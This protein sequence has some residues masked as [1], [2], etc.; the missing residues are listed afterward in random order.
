[1]NMHNNP[2]LR[3]VIALRTLQETF[4]LVANSERNRI[5]AQIRQVLLNVYDH[6]CQ[7]CKCEEATAIDHIIPINPREEDLER[8]ATIIPSISW[9]TLDCI[10]NYMA[11]CQPCNSKKNNKLLSDD[12]LSFFLAKAKE[13]KDEIRFLLAVENEDEEAKIYGKDIQPTTEYIKFLSAAIYGD[14]S[15]VENFIQRGVYSESYETAMRACAL[16]GQHAVLSKFI[17]TINSPEILEKLRS[18][19]F[20]AKEQYDGHLQ[21][22]STLAAMRN[23]S[24]AGTISDIKLFSPNT[25][26]W[27]RILPQIME[28]DENVT[29]I[30]YQL[31]YSVADGDNKE[32]EMLLQKGTNVDAYGRAVLRHA[33][34]RRDHKQICMLVL[35]KANFENYENEVLEAS[36]LND[37]V[38]LFRQALENDFEPSSLDKALRKALA[39]GTPK[40]YSFVSEL[41]KRGATCQNDDADKLLLASVIGKTDIV[42]QIVDGKKCKKK[43][44][45][46][47][48]QYAVFAGQHDV[49]AVFKGYWRNVTLWKKIRN[50]LQ[51]IAKSSCKLGKQDFGHLD[52]MMDLINSSCIG[53]EFHF[54]N[55]RDHDYNNPFDNSRIDSWGEC[56]KFIHSLGDTNFYQ[57]YISAVSLGGS[58]KTDIDALLSYALAAGDTAEA[59]LHI[60]NGASATAYNNSAFRIA[61]SRGDLE[62]VL[63]LIS[64]DANYEGFEDWALWAAIHSRNLELTK[65]ILANGADERTLGFALAKV[66]SE[67]PRNLL[68]F[69]KELANAGAIFDPAYCSY[70]HKRGFEF[71]CSTPLIS[72][73]VP[74]EESI[75]QEGAN[76]YIRQGGKKYS[77]LKEFD[78]S[79]VTDESSLSRKDYS[80]IIG[81]LMYDCGGSAY[82]QT[83]LNSIM[84]SSSAAQGLAHHERFIKDPIEVNMVSI[85]LHFGASFS[86]YIAERGLGS[87]RSE[88]VYN[89]LK[90]YGDD[91]LIKPYIS[92]EKYL[93]EYTIG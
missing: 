49:T 93:I 89:W 82:A 7:Y 18:I 63:L 25:Q 38:A 51:T 84:F 35:H 14:V 48:I 39:S 69:V 22:L 85:F 34:D 86:D 40:I 15:T 83:G 50:G 70:A 78:D 1:M 12:Q 88:R 44:L 26:Y 45:D 55:I 36:I 92:N 8:I 87:F 77:T 33:V 73:Y 19:V 30:D 21:I 24:P 32:M 68:L 61:A 29:E 66:V 41:T 74:D 80:N 90:V 11:S 59:N 57:S 65:K 31:V 46:K 13:K 28:P 81:T 54:L 27:E 71:F 3:R 76:K 4:L 62:Q 10:D 72:I 43:D 60:Q 53:D 52:L 37:D 64:S 47:A 5:S 17:E 42:R 91:P 58:E 23:A 2:L 20:K 56:F 6:Q 16:F 9:K 67:K 75:Y 79:F